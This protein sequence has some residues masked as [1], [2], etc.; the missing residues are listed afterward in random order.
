MSTVIKHWDE[1]GRQTKQGH[2]FEPSVANW[3]PGMQIQ[4]PRAFTPYVS[5]R[6]AARGKKKWKEKK[7]AHVSHIWKYYRFITLKLLSRNTTIC[8]CSFC[9]SSLCHADPKHACRSRNHHQ[10]HQLQ[11][12]FFFSFSSLSHFGGVVSA[13]ASRQKGCGSDSESGTFVCGVCLFFLCVCCFP[14]ND[15]PSS[16][17]PKACMLGD[18][19]TRMCIWMLMVVCLFVALWKT[20]FMSRLA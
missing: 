5:L 17:G 8:M 10:Q 13:A 1:A 20:D 19:E 12:A 16:D 7:A 14:P 6:H 15:V 11:H 18:L 4:R 3:Q 2:I 9:F